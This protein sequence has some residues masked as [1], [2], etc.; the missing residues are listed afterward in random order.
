MI[1]HS[2]RLAAALLDLPITVETLVDWSPGRG[3]SWYPLAVISG[4]H[5]SD[6]TQQYR[7]NC[8]GVFE[9]GDYPIGATGIHTK[10]CRL[11]VNQK[12]SAMGFGSEILSAGVY[13]IVS[14]ANG[15]TN[16][17]LTAQSFETECI[18]QTFPTS[19]NFPSTSGMTM[20]QQAEKLITEAV[21]DASYIWDDDLLYN[22]A[23]QTMQ[24]DTD[25]WGTVD[26]ARTDSSIMGSLGGVAYCTS[27]GAF[28]FSKTPTLNQTPA[29]IIRRGETL[30]SPSVSDDRTNV[31]NM[32][33][34]TGTPADGSAVIGPVIVWDDDPTSLTYAGPDPINHPELAGDFGVRPYRYD[35]P[36]IKSTG[37]AKTTGKSLLASVLGVHQVV[38]ADARYNPFYEAG[39]VSLIENE[40]G[41]LVPYLLD[42]VATTWGSAK[43]TLTTRSPKEDLS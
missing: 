33:V 39:D 29:G 5:S 2:T 31:F 11:R 37:Q 21:P 10:G 1:A 27:F 9:K 42:V 15:T 43:M 13:S 38:T 14:I 6:A 26:G 22:T 23:M 12:V 17:G 25:R 40:S 4:G 32:V 8:S 34:V 20:R 30:I 24:Q 18:D 41:V 16:F 36:L 28:R 35:S 19:R 7:W 3:K